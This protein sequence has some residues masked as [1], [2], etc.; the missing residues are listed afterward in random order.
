M[1]TVKYITHISHVKGLSESE[2]ESLKEIENKFA[3]RANNYYLNLVN[4]DDP[5]DPIRRIIIPN[6]DEFLE[7]GALDAS[8]ESRYVRVPGVEHKYRDTALFISQDTCGA[9]CRFCFRKRLFMHDNKEVN[10]RYD[11]GI[12]YIRNHP[13]ILNILITGGDP[14]IMS[15]GKIENL[16]RRLHTIPHV[17][18]IRIGTKLPLFNPYRIL[19]DPSLIEMIRRYST[20]AKRIYFMLHINHPRELTRQSRQ[21]INMLREA[22]AALCNQTPL[23]RGVNDDVNV[24]AKLFLELNLLDVPPYYIFQCRPTLGNKTFAV[25]IME[26]WRILEEAKDK[27]SGLGRRARM[28]MSHKT[29]KIEVLAVTEKQTIM[30][31]HRNA[32]KNDMSRIMVYKSNPDAYWLD[33]FEEYQDYCLK[34]GLE[35]DKDPYGNW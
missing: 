20:G 15:T 25:P 22:G 31:Y 29:G 23:I 33:D 6:E 1:G 28:V 9:F 8:G 14:L 30:K 10:R 27:V 16:I 24:L 13:E 34:H 17:K 4:W 12:E 2:K 11:E 26:G 7:W 5:Y 18:I 19:E 32:D 3:F 35:G 21:A